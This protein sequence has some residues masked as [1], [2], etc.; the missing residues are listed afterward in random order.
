MAYTWEAPA[1]TCYRFDTSESGFDTLLRIYDGCFSSLA[2][3]DDGGDSTDSEIEFDTTAGTEY[4]LV[5][6]GYSTSHSGSFQ[7]DINTCASGGPEIEGAVSPGGSCTADTDLG[8][9]TGTPAYTGTTSSESDDLTG[10][11]ALYDH[12]DGHDGRDYVMQWSPPSTGTYCIDTIGSD[13]YD[14]VLYVLDTDCE[15]EFACD[16]DSGGSFDSQLEVTVSSGSSYYIV[17]DESRAVSGGDFIL[18]I[19]LGGC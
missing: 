14:P 3:D 8:T 12:S 16:D 9:A 7:L 17:V 11:C 6:D 1:S 4:V 18:N 5:I 2:C 15:A 19:E 10:S 13:V